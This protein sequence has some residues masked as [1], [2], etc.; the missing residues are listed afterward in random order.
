MTKDVP[1]ARPVVF[2]VGAAG[3]AS[4]GRGELAAPTSE[5][6]RA[7]ERGMRRV[8]ATGRKV[9]RMN[10]DEFRTTMCCWSSAHTPMRPLLAPAARG[11]PRRRPESHVRHAARH[12]ILGG[13]ASI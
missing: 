6:A 10:I 13:L 1:L 5:M 9:I 11:C 2:A 8:E 7:L 12:D 3:F 4:T